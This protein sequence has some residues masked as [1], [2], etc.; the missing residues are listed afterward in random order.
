MSLIICCSDF[1]FSICGGVLPTEAKI[2]SE[3]PIEV[4]VS[5]ASTNKLKI[6]KY[7]LYFVAGCIIV[8]LDYH[9]K[10]GAGIRTSAP[11]SLRV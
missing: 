6:A 2:V 3:V 8:S 11:F 9:N 4:S 7:R 10:K 1:S 5:S